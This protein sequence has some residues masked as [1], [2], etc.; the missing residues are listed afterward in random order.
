MLARS[1]VGGT[2]Q[3]LLADVL[4]SVGGIRTGNR[5]IDP[6][7][8]VLQIPPNRSPELLGAFGASQI[9]HLLRGGSRRLLCQTAHSRRLPL[10]R[11]LRLAHGLAHRRTGG[12]RT[13]RRPHPHV[14]DLLPELRDRG[15]GF[16]DPAP[17][18]LRHRC[19]HA[20]GDHPAH[21][22]LETPAPQHVA[23]GV[24]RGPA[25]AGLSVTGRLRRGRLPRPGPRA[26]TA[27]CGGGRGQCSRHV[28][29]RAPGGVQGLRGIGARE[30]LTSVPD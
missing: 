11:L 5:G 20:S 23:E 4:R 14:G 28:L 27:H 30:R 26:T 16:L 29:R 1:S 3:L 13:A 6:R 9:H 7:D 10:Q 15:G 19:R 22:A 25:A 24:L 8:S 2:S 21:G 17:A 18:H 12:G